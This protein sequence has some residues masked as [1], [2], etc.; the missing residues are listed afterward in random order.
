M[1]HIP[2]DDHDP[3]DPIVGLSVARPYGYIIKDAKPHAFL[4]FGM[5]P[6]W[7]DSA[8]YMFYLSVKKGVHSAHHC[9]C[10]SQGCFPRVL[11]DAGIS[12]REL[13]PAR[14]NVALGDLQIF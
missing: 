8:K 7:A 13:L 11:A 1:M 2:V 14:F 10:S 3:F 9:A 4:R 5:M 6:R 12:C